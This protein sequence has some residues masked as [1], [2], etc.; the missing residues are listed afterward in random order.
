MVKHPLKLHDVSDLTP[1]CDALNKAARERINDQTGTSA[2]D[3]KLLYTEIAY[4]EDSK[5][6]RIRFDD[7]AVHDVLKHSGYEKKEFKLSSGTMP[8]DWYKVDLETAIKAI[9]AIKNGQEVIDGPPVVEKPKKEID[10]R[11]EQKQAIADTIAHFK[12]GHR[13]L[14][15]LRCVLERPSALLNLFAN[16]IMAEF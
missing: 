12:N 8:Q 2:T 5:G 16:R 7:N 4:F 9:A 1:N 15:M 11:D 14:G 6:N 10:F 3:Y 13:Y